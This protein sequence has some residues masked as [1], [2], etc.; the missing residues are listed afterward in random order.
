MMAVLNVLRI[1]LPPVTI[2]VD[3]AEVVRGFGEGPEWSTAAGRDGGDLWREVWRRMDDIGGGV[4]IKKV[5]AHT[6]E[7]DIDGGV[8]SARDRYGN[9]HADAEAKRGAR[10][11]ESLSPVGIAKGELVKGLRWMGW[12][13]R[14]AAVWRPD[15]DE[16]EGEEV[17]R[18]AGGRDEEVKPGRVAT[19]LR[20]LVW[21]RGLEW[22]C[23]RCGRT[24]NTDQ[25]RRV[26]TSSRCLGSAVGRM[27]A[28]TC[29]DPDAIGRCCIERKVDLERRGWR[30]RGGVEGGEGGSAGM[31]STFE[32]EEEH[33]ESGQSEDSEGKEGEGGGMGV[34]GGGVR[35]AVGEAGGGCGGAAAASAAAATA[36]GSASASAP[37]RSRSPTTLPWKRDPDWMQAS[38]IGVAAREAASAVV[39]RTSE[40]SERPAAAAAA[41]A[42]AAVEPQ[43]HIGI[44]DIPELPV[45]EAQELLRLRETGGVRRHEEPVHAGGS[46][47]RNW[48]TGLHEPR[49]E[50]EVAAVATS[51]GASA[52]DADADSSAG[53]RLVG[54]EFG[55]EAMEEEG[56]A[57]DEQ[58]G[59]G[60]GGR[61]SDRGRKNK[62]DALAGASTASK[63]PRRPSQDTAAQGGESGS[64]EARGR[65]SKRPAMPSEHRPR[66]KRARQ[67]GVAE[68]VDPSPGGQDQSGRVFGRRYTGL[69]ADPV[70][71][72]QSRGHSLRITGPMIWCAKC[73]RYALR[74]VGKS[75]K[76]ECVGQALGA[77]ATRLA[78]LKEG[79]HPLTNAALVDEGASLQAI[80]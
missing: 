16:V 48:R 6:S 7:E 49:R 37:A 65:G 74:R 69:A 25:K 31:R 63:R 55:K 57:E 33:D 2:H 52:E 68:A 15:V 26:M 36:G 59:I 12:A 78:R 30:P 71:A 13:R 28:R 1:A 60:R 46:G 24:A 44:D 10:L 66:D 61:S 11:A 29:G 8:I 43:V 3:N 4:E 51:T 32:E 40:G 34:A 64:E 54:R 18:R 70:D 76:G 79:R 21:E 73:A 5:K 58:E 23:R 38:Y 72:Q 62:K 47:P 14:Y 80:G 67:E 50:Q 9:L 53:G 41:V 27:L 17:G 45:R 39:A 77:Y 42:A 35:D 56:A 19:G 20:H 75:L 22:T